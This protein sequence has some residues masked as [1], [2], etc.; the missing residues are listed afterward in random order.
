[1]LIFALIHK[2]IVTAAGAVK[3]DETEFH[4]KLSSCMTPLWNFTSM[5]NYREIAVLFSISISDVLVS[6]GY[7]F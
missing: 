3:S 4:A 2:A 7:E 6:T 1:M 5:L